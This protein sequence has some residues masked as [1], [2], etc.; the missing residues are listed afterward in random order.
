M[1]RGQPVTFLS[2]VP[3]GAGAGLELPHPRKTVPLPTGCRVLSPANPKYI[4]LLSAIERVWI[5]I[6]HKLFSGTMLKGML[7]FSFHTQVDAF[8]APSHLDV[9]I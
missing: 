9:I 5:V 4:R 6:D 7:F 8:D 2:R 1:G 3:S